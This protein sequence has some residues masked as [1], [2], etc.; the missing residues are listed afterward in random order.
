GALLRTDPPPTD[1]P[2][3]ILKF[4]Q[5]LDG[6]IASRGGDSKW[7]SGESERTLSHALRA[8]CDA[9][10][11]GVGTVLADDP[12]LTVRLVPGASPL[13]VVLDSTLRIPDAAH[14]LDAEAGTIIV[15]TDRA[16]PKRVEA[17]LRRRIAVRIV[18]RGLDGVNLHAAL[19]ALR[20]EGIESLLVEGGARVITSFLAEQVTD[21]VI[22]AIAP[23]ILGSG[24]EAV[25]DLQSRSP[26]DAV[27]LVGSTTF[28]V[29]DDVLVSG[30]VEYAADSG[31]VVSL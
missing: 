5:T 26:R 2:R 28:R 10:L 14:V 15:T 8:G 21:R 23:S 1:R 3:V 25:G 6:R 7:I 24:T 30:D 12:Q 19:R 18:E 16:D 31:P 13:R 4:A 27:R 11:V 17:L 22:V 20:E 9:V 29:G